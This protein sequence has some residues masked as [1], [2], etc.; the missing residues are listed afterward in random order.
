MVGHQSSQKLL[1]LNLGSRVL[2]KN[3]GQKQHLIHTFR[4]TQIIAKIHK[5]IVNWGKK[6]TML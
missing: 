4:N 3:R 1:I 5:N 6:F 2:V